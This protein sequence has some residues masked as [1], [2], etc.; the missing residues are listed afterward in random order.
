MKPL[1]CKYV[2]DG[3]LL[4]CDAPIIVDHNSYSGYTHAEGA[5]W[6]HWASPT[7]YGP[8]ASQDSFALCSVCKLR[9]PDNP[10]HVER[11][12]HRFKAKLRGGK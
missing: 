2:M 6:L 8:Q 4:Y 11:G 7:P 3:H 9:G 12:G 1:K 10:A 5:D